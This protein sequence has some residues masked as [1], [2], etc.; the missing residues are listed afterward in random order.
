M[1]RTETIARINARLSALDDDGVATVADI[2]DEM[3]S[4]SDLP[5]ALTPREFALIEQSK[6][7]FAAGNTFSSDGLDAFLDAATAKRAAVPSK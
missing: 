5:R 1:T 4:G 6:A 2:V 7:D 3:T